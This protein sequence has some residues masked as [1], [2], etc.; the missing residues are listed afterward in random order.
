MYAGNH[1]NIFYK[2]VFNCSVLDLL[3]NNASSRK[4]SLLLKIRECL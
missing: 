1:D 2:I 3:Y 4:F